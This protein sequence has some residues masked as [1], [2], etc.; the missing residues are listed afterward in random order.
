MVGLQPELGEE[1]GGE[2]GGELRGQNTFKEFFKLTQV[3]TLVFTC[4]FGFVSDS[5]LLL[6]PLS[7]LLTDN[8]SRDFFF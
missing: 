4:A 6:N 5:V 8:I 3:L 7:L 1:G 2:G